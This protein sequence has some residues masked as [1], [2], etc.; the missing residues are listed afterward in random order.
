MR[1][2]LPAAIWAGVWPAG[3]QLLRKEH[4][5]CH[6]QVEHKLTMCPWRKEGPRASWAALV[7]VQPTGS[8]E[9][10]GNPLYFTFQTTSGISCPVLGFQVEDR[11]LTYWI[12]SRKGHE[13][14]QGLENIMHEERQ[15]WASGTKAAQTRTGTGWLSEVSSNLTL[16]WD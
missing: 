8:R 11:V 12:K 10:T 2:D 14:D 9:V 1:E 4:G 16:V 3:K 15:L 6:R 5:D 13:D 7:R